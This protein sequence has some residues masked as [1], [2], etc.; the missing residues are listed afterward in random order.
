MVGCR[1]RA[2]PILDWNIHPRGQKAGSIS[3]LLGPGNSKLGG[4]KCFYYYFSWS[5]EFGLAAPAVWVLPQGASLSL[6]NTLP[7]PPLGL[8]ESRCRWPLAHK[9]CWRFICSGYEEGKHV[10]TTGQKWK[11]SNLQQAGNALDTLRKVLE[12][13]K[14]EL[15][16]F[17]Q[18]VRC[19]W[20]LTVA[21]SCAGGPPK[22]HN[23]DCLFVLSLGLS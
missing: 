15:A 11:W 6:E 18:S 17:W 12:H 16:R 10:S 23:P 2:L 19:F 4:E 8:S 5:L 1:C 22:V 7:H 13:G 3:T 9:V 20:Y 21:W 14:L